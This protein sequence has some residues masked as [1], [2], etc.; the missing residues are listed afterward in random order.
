MNTEQIKA[1]LMLAETKNFSCI[2]DGL[3]VSQ[4]MV[5]TRIYELEAKTGQP[6]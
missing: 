4:S 5:S 3:A 6:L 2:A 1:F